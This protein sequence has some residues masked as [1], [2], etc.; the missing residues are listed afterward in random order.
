MG[1]P[2][3][4]A[5]AFPAGFIKRLTFST[6]LATNADLLATWP[7]NGKPTFACEGLPLGVDFTEGALRGPGGVR[8][9]VGHKLGTRRMGTH[10]HTQSEFN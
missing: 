10:T 9:I 8:R 4:P 2:P 6:D 5:K 7:Q 1:T 3:L